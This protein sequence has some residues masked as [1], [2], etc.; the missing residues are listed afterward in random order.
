MKVLL[1]DDEPDMLLIVDMALRKIGGYETVQ[2][3]NPLHVLEIAKRERPDVILMDVFMAAMDGPQVL[4]LLAAEPD[5]CAIPV[6]FL[7]G[8]A[9]P[10]EARRLI[11]MGARGVI[12]KPTGP[13]SMVE[14]FRSIL[15]TDQMDSTTKCDV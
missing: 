9:S 7:T 15:K 12:A 14:Q 13:R 8:S 2:V 4:A 6:I 10:E 11:E 3:Q 1:V 5:T